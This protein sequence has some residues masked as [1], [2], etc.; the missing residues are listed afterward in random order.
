MPLGE[1]VVF[2]NGDRL[3]SIYVHDVRE[4]E[5]VPALFQTIA[6][7]DTPEEVNYYRHGG[8]MQFVLRSLLE[9]A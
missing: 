4:Y 3:A 8:I 5:C 1:G 7:A 9:P 2:R 6:R